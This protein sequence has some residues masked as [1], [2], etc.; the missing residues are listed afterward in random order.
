MEVEVE[1]RGDNAGPFGR[2][3]EDDLLGSRY[4]LRVHGPKVTDIGM[5]LNIDTLNMGL[6]YSLFS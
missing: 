3:V 4:C 6:R 2:V 1:V 5:E